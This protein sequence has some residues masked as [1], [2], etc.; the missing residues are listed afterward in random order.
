[1]EKETRGWER[2]FSAIKGILLQIERHFLCNWWILYGE[3]YY[4]QTHEI[5]MFIEPD[6]FVFIINSDRIKNEIFIW[7]RTL[8][9]SSY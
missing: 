4:Q 6:E 2:K 1:M 3:V 9:C 5:P 7:Y 8:F